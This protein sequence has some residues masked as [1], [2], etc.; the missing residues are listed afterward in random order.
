MSDSQITVALADLRAGMEAI[1]RASAALYILTEQDPKFGTYVLARL[2]HVHKQL[3]TFTL[4]D[5]EKMAARVA[6][7]DKFE[8][9][10]FSVRDGG[11]PDVA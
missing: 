9:H 3:A 10:H 8:N 5:L 11:G 2:Q 4:P 6:E 1:S 7:A